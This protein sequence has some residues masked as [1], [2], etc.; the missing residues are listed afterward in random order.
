[1][2]GAFIAG[3]ILHRRKKAHALQVGIAGAINSLGKAPKKK[4][5]QHEFAL[6]CQK[7]DGTAHLM[8]S[9][10]WRVL[11]KHLSLLFVSSQWDSSMTGKPVTRSR[12]SQVLDLQT[13][14]LRK[15]TRSSRSVRR[16][17]VH[18]DVPIPSTNQFLKGETERSCDCVYSSVCR[19]FFC[20]GYEMV[21]CVFTS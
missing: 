7:T 20:L 3:Q 19:A 2:C 17:T 10:P 4:N 16:C 13:R 6:F 5:Q 15:G 18:R 14:S 21:Q 9:G 8:T 12:T 1:M 11:V